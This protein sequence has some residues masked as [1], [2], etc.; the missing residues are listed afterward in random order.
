MS[1]TK[2]R[3]KNQIVKDLFEKDADLRDLIDS[4]PA[5]L[6]PFLQTASRSLRIV[7]LE[8]RHRNPLQIQ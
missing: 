7:A 2:F 4:I 8:V 5:D 3:T 6:I 1:K